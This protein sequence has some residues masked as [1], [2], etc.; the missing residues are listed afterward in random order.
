MAYET[1][2]FEQEG[3][4]GIL[5]LNRPQ[6]LNALNSQVISELLSLLGQIEK[7]VMPKVLII[8][9]AGEKAFVAGTDIVEMEKLS[10]FEAREFASN[11]NIDMNHKERCLNWKIVNQL[12]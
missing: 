1:I 10:S 3:P 8:T 7:E 6:A 9:G 4:V 5:K 12:C 11:I 2:L